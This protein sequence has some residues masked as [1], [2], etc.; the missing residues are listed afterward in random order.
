MPGVGRGWSKSPQ[1]LCLMETAPTPLL[2]LEGREGNGSDKP[3]V[4]CPAGVTQSWGFS[5]AAAAAWIMLRPLR[6]FGGV[7]GVCRSNLAVR[8]GLAPWLEPTCAL[9]AALDGEGCSCLHAGWLVL[10]CSSAQGGLPSKPRYVGCGEA[11]SGVSPGA[12]SHP[13]P[14]A[15]P[16]TL[17]KGGSKEAAAGKGV[18]AVGWG[19]RQGAVNQ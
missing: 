13:A 15:W 7:P 16:W 2:W 17:P 5:Q 11:A 14:P 18:S 10:L 6:P 8:G 9:S 3:T 12:S 1:T 19:G 4:G